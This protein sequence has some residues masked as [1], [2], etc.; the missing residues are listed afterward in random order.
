MLPANECWEAMPAL[1]PMHA[2]EEAPM[3]MK[4]VETVTNTAM[5]RVQGVGSTHA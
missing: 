5:T 4:A 3:Q 1:F 2:P